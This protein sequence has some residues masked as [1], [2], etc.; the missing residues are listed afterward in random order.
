MARKHNYFNF[1]YIQVEILLSIGKIPK[2]LA[3]KTKTDISYLIKTSLK[4]LVKRM[5]RKATKGRKSL[6]TTI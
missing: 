2:A 3:L 4:D 5:K 1:V 6:Q